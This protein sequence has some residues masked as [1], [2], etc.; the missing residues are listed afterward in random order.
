MRNIAKSAGMQRFSCPRYV[1]RHVRKGHRELSQL[2]NYA[3]QRVAQT[4]GAMDIPAFS[5]QSPR[6]LQARAPGNGGPSIHVGT[7]QHTR[8]VRP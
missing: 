6:N 3:V 2:H 8:K 5:T 1:S 4:P 7:H